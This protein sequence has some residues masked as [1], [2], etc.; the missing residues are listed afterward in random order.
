MGPVR[1]AHERPWARLCARECLPAYAPRETRTPTRLTPDKALNLACGVFVV[2]V[3]S[4]ASIWSGFRRT[5]WTIWTIWDGMDVANALPAEVARDGSY[6]RGLSGGCRRPGSRLLAADGAAHFLGDELAAFE[7]P[8][9]RVRPRAAAGTGEMDPPVGP[10]QV[11]PVPRELAGRAV[12]RTAAITPTFT[13]VNT[14][15]EP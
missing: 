4:R 9:H 13:S 3:V 10:P 15:I 5:G 12:Q 14:R 11:R 1:N 2:S 8:L 7:R 6:R